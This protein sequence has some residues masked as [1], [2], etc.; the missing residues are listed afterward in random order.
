MKPTLSK[1]LA[2]KKRTPKLGKG[3]KLSTGKRAS[4]VLGILSTP[5]GYK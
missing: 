4:N 3:T 1:T 2:S 5:G